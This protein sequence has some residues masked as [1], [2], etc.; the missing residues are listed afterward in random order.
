MKT[1]MKNLYMKI[2]LLVVFLAASIAAQAQTIKGVVKDVEGFPLPGVAVMVKG[3]TQGVSTGMDGDY[4]I[5]IQNAKGKTLVFSC[6]G[7][8]TEEIVIGNETTI[9]LDMFE[10]TN[11]LDETVVIGYA[12][13]KRRDLLGSVSSVDNKTLTATPVASVTEALTGK[14]A[15][16]QVTT[17]EG[18]PD[19]DV[20]IRV[21]GT[22]SITQDSSPLYIVDGFPVESI[23]DIPSADIQSIDILKDAFSTAIYGSRGANGVVLV[24]TKSGSDGKVS[25]S[26]NGYAG[27]KTI[28]NKSAITVMDS[29][30]FVRTQYEIESIRNKVAETY[31]PMFGSFADI[32][33]YKGLKTNDWVGQIFGNTG[34]NT[35]H[36][37]SVTGG[38]DKVKW[39]ASYNFLKD[40]AIMTGSNYARHNLALKTQF[41][42]IKPLTID[43]NV[44]YSNT[45]VRGAGSNS[46]NDAGSSSGTS[47]RLKHAVQYTP[48]PVT[49]AASDSDLEEDY[50]DNA[51][52]LKSIADNDKKR[53]RDN[54]TFNAGVTWKIIEN[55]N[56]R[57]EGGLD[58]Y[59][60]KD[61][62]FYGL[63]TY[64]V[65]NSATIKN[66][67]ATMYSD[68]NRQKLRNTN[69]LSYNFEKVFDTYSKHSLDLLLGQET[70]FT[71]SNVYKTTV[72]GLPSF[73]DAEKAWNFMASGT[74]ISSNNYY[75]PNDLLVSFFGRANYSYDSRYSVSATVRSDGSSKFGKGNQWGFFPSAAVSWTI[76]NEEFMSG[77]KRWLDNLKLRYT[78]GTAGNNNIPSGVSSMLFQ[79]NTSTWISQGGT[80]WSTTKVDGKTIMPN[81]NLTWETT[82]SHNVG[83]DFSL[84]HT[85][86]NGSVEAYYNDTRDLLIQFPTTGTGYDY[87]YRNMGV[88]NNKGIEV[89]LSAVLI[90]AKNAGLTIGGNVSLNKNTVKTLGGLSRIE[91]QSLWASTEVGTDYLVEPGQPLGNMYGYISDGMYTTSDFTFDPEKKVWNL[92]QGVVDCSTIVGTSYMRPGAPKFKDLDG[93]GKPDKTVIG[94]AVPVGTGGFYINANAYGF[95]FSANFNFVF[96]NKIYNANKVEFSSS[97]KYS[98]RNLLSSMSPEKRWTNIDWKT[99]ELVND[100][101]KLNAMNSGV[102][103]W[104]PAVG[105]AIFSSWAVEDGS[106]LRLGTVTLG[107][108]LPEKV[109]Q[110]FHCQKLRIYATGTNLFCLT[111]YTGYDPEV[112]TRR[113]TPLTPGVDYSAYPKSVGVVGG[114]NITF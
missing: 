100:A 40:N 46:I 47:A 12:T 57:V 50:G 39:T 37:V 42:P 17:T 91:S 10:D 77:S 43:F 29:Y 102:S 35:N 32:D 81:E 114:L 4:S 104:S 21:R 107:Y 23:S 109:T 112:D 54:W 63:T 64:Y 11:F 87:Q 49:G 26:Y 72:E 25:I 58:T 19:A 5:D 95:D 31:E 1:S 101:D 53:V 55:L 30:D 113:S 8:R 24:T 71:R 7:M 84:F 86:L 75:N 73:F 2:S 94:N 18:D 14:M 103:M 68:L 111:R 97:R 106:F 69:T 88:V 41:K 93:D 56:L 90:E 13:V 82:I 51:P 99:G 6:I 85:R 59:N 83:L 45:A 36:N 76:S 9:N 16:V 61:N 44:R 105:N 20:K 70:I 110:K 67:P 74:S 52:P 78:Y 92:N 33:Q 62:N 48:I 79:A 80:Y 108:T 89:T 34:F 27:V 98:R 3:T 28:A 96:G 60:Q 66:Q 22:G 65:G 38:S 15:G